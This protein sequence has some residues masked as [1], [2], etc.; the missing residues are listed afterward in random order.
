MIFGIV[1]PE[2]IPLRGSVFGMG[3]RDA[4]NF[5][6]EGAV[7]KRNQTQLSPIRALASPDQIVEGGQ[8][9]LLMIQ[10]PVQHGLPS[11]KVR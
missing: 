9:V 4:K 5:L 1:P 6:H 10:M 7:F 11:R 2:V 3:E 8:R